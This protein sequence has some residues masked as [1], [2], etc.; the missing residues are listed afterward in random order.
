M[1][2]ELTH[3]SCLLRRP[4]T[5]AS[6]ISVLTDKQMVQISEALKTIAELVPCPKISADRFG[7]EDQEPSEKNASLWHAFWILWHYSSI[8]LS[9]PDELL[10]HGIVECSLPQAIATA[11]DLTQ[12]KLVDMRKIVEGESTNCLTSNVHPLTKS[13]DRDIFRIVSQGHFLLDT[14]SPNDSLA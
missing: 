7:I 3:V 2:R 9:R 1:T 11:C 14:R 13:L 6:T 10:V 12:S 5:Q 4:N 8:T